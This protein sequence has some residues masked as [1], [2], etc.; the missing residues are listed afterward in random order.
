MA[1]TRQIIDK[2]NDIRAAEQRMSLLYRRAAEMVTG[3]YREALIGE[4]LNHANDEDSHAS[5]VMR[6]IMALGGDIG[7]YIEPL[8]VC[9]NLNDILTHIDEYEVQGIRRW[10]EL[11]RMLSKDDSFLHTI[12][13]ILDQETEHSDDVKNWLRKDYAEKSMGDIGSKRP[14]N[15]ANPQFASPVQKG[16]PWQDRL[17]EHSQHGTPFTRRGAYNGHVP[18]LEPSVPA[19]LNPPLVIS[20]AVLR[21]SKPGASGMEFQRK[22]DASGKFAPAGASGAETTAAE[23]VTDEKRKAEL[24]AAKM[25]EQQRKPY[26][27]AAAG[28]QALRKLRSA[29]LSKAGV[30]GM[31]GPTEDQQAQPMEAEPVASLMDGQPLYED[32]YHPAHEQ[33][34]PQQHHEA[35]QIH[36]EMADA[37]QAAGDPEKEMQ[38]RMRAAVHEERAQ[39]S[40]QPM[41]RAFEVPGKE[42]N[43]AMKM[44]Q[45]FKALNYSY[46]SDEDMNQ[47]TQQRDMQKPSFGQRT[48]GPIPGMKHTATG[49]PVGPQT[50]PGFGPD[51]SPPMTP[52]PPMTPPPAPGMEVQG[53]PM[54]PP[55]APSDAVAGMPMDLSG[56]GQQPRIDAGMAPPMQEDATQNFDELIGYA[57]GAAPED[58]SDQQLQQMGQMA[59]P[60]PQGMEGLAAMSSS[61]PSPVG[62]TPPGAVPPTP[63]GGNDVDA[64]AAKENAPPPMQGGS[65][66][67][68]SD[69]VSEPQQGIP[70]GDKTSEASNDTS[71]DGGSSLQEGTDEGPANEQKDEKKTFG[72][73]ALKSW[74]A[75]V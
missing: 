28:K 37:A 56:Q 29:G 60:P 49:G 27:E 31:E 63:F 18:S 9:R 47:F 42:Q 67:D 51:Q 39:D 53:L 44:D 7:T 22:R 38:C 4:F 72:L 64:Q 24:R 41:D 25:R 70:G 36:N 46:S 26:E 43:P 58:I 10:Q 8:P 23:D 75:R 50:N 35:S 15:W 61:P 13:T 40:K 32:P 62:E 55:P 21:P 12:S 59:P 3:P 52:A 74:S 5:I 69:N 57:P 16:T 45:A 34:T 73:D 2:L 11:E 14:I 54:S 33:M 1:S 6:R 71:S 30:P 66:S 20:K 65:L 17:Q 68:T 48:E 19:E